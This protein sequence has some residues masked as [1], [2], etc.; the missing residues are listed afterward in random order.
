MLVVGLVGLVVLGLILSIVGGEFDEYADDSYY[1][2][3]QTS[4]LDAVEGPCEDML[5]A[6][7]EVEMFDDP[8]NM[9]SAIKTFA[10][11]AQ[12]VA[13]AIAS[14][15]PNQDS[16]E[17]QADWETL[18]SDLT[19]YAGNLSDAGAGALYSSTHPSG[20]MPAMVRMAYGSDAY[21]EVPSVIVALDPEVDEYNSGYY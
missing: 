1:Y 2:V 7:A 6:G 10:V 14:A 15:N 5:E 20:E 16:K 3:D 9:A 21:C 18:S 11:T 12:G 8:K 13:D 4:V 19:A 17:W